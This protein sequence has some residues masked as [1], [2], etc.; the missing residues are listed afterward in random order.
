MTEKPSE[1]RMGNRAFGLALGGV[2]GIVAAL[3]W[4]LSGRVPM[5]AAVPAGALVL[6][7]L[8]APDA[9]LPLSRLWAVV[10]RRLAVVSNHIVL[11]AFFYLVITPFA[12]ALRLLRRRLMLRRPEPALDTYWAP[13]TRQASAETYPDMS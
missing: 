5:W 9:L 8:I 7:G 1:H 10:A 12:L 13:I 6:L 11:G 4:L 3:G 2:L